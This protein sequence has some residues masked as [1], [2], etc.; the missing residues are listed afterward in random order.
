M[1]LLMQGL[2]S[3]VN[4]TLL[5]ETMSAHRGAKQKSRRKAATSVFDPKATSRSF[6]P[7]S[8]EV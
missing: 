8:V 4:P 7:R 2:L 1:A 5:Y 3:G 6:Q